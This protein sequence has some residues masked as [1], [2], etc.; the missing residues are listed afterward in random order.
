MAGHENVADLPAIALR[1]CSRF[2]FSSGKCGFSAR[3]MKASWIR[4]IRKLTMKVHSK[5]PLRIT[6]SVLRDACVTGNYYARKF[7]ELGF[8]SSTFDNI[9]T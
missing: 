5:V 1:F 7:F 6:R 3:K 8:I 9:S 2:G 4:L